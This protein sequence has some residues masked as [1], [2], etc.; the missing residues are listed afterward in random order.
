MGKNAQREWFQPSVFRLSL[1]PPVFS[2]VSGVLKTKVILGHPYPQRVA[3]VSTVEGR[4]L[5]GPCRADGL[6]YLTSSSFFFF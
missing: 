6:K 1:N 3:N 5:N 2:A 4:S